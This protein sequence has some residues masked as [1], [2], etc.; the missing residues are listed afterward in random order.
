[1]RKK[2]RAPLREQRRPTGAVEG[3]WVTDLAEIR[4]TLILCWKCDV[5]WRASAARYGYEKLRRW[6]K[7]WGGVIG[8]CDGCRE[9]GVQRRAYAHGSLIDK[10]S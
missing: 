4:Q 9:P 8:K 10:I 6:S 7:I 1:M 3:S 2:N 5:K